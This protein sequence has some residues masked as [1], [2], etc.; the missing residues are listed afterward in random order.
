MITHLRFYNSTSFDPYYNL[1]LEQYLMRTM[2]PDACILFLWQNQHTVVLG[3]NQNPW[4]ECRTSLLEADGGHLAR[5]FSG[6]GA[7]YHDLGNL[8]FTFLLPTS[9]YDVPKQLSVILE[10]CRELGIPAEATGR[11]DLTVEGKKFSGNAFYKN[12]DIACHHGTIMV[13]VDREKLGHYLNPSAAKLQAKGVASVRSRVVNL[14]EISPGLTC[15]DLHGLLKSA[16]SKVYGLDC[17]SG[18]LPDSPE[19]QKL[20][21][22]FASWEWLYGPKLPFSFS[23]ESRYSWG[24][25]SLELNV[26][27]GIIRNAKVC[28]DS[29]D[30]TLAQRLETALIGSRF[31]MEDMSAA[32]CGAFQSEITICQDLIRMLA[33]QEI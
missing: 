13:Q 15:G 18:P 32:I 6:G 20:R 2:E 3:R 31:A 24:E 21:E 23:C 16:F 1:A 25:I 19:I 8:N 28:T 22:E 5:R 12:G 26:D 27:G 7:V 30:W 11:N 4:R 9:D 33:E 10:A 17:E 14:S 29:M